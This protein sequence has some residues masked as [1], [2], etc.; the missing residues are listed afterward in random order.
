MPPGKTSCNRHSRAVTMKDED[1]T[2]GLL[3]EIVRQTAQGLLQTHGALYP[4]GVKVT[5][6]EPR[7]T[8]FF[9]ADT[10]PGA[11]QAEL[12]GAVLEDLRAPVDAPLL[13]VALVLAVDTEAGQRLFAA[14]IESQSYRVVALFKYWS[15]PD[16]TTIIGEPELRTE[17]MVS[18]GL[19]WP[20]V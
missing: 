8:T 13:G 9:P 7:P 2:L 11:P 6:P 1:W 12:L 18:A 16:G 19:D 4:Y 14:Q 20:R 17:L 5:G 15:G 10:R 3:L